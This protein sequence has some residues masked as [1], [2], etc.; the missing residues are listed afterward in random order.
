MEKI[1]CECPRCRSRFKVAPEHIG[2]TG[3]CAK[4]QE[5][6]VVQDVRSAGQI[7]QKTQTYSQSDVSKNTAVYSS[8]SSDKTQTYSNAADAQKTQTYSDTPKGAAT[9]T[10]HAAGTHSDS[11]TPYVYDL[12]Q[13]QGAT[14]QQV[15][16]AHQLGI[17]DVVTLNGSA[18][19]ITGIISQ[20]TGEAVIYNIRNTQQQSLALKLYFEFSN[21]KDEP[22]PEALQRIKEIRDPDILRL[23]DFGTGASKYQNRYCFEICDFAMGGTLLTRNDYSLDCVRQTIIPQIIKGIRTLHQHKIFHCDLKP[24]NIFWLDTDRTDAVIGDYGSA[25]TFEESSQKGLTHTSTTKGTNFYLAPEQPRGIVS[26]KN[27]YYSFGMILLH[28]LYPQFVNRDALHKI[29]ER[30]YERRPIIDYDAK[31]GNLNELIAGLTLADVS[32]RWGEKQVEQWLQGQSISVIYNTTTDIHPI[33]LGTITIKTQAEFT[34]YVETNID[35]FDNLIEDS[36]GYSMVLRWIADIQDLG[37][38]KTFDKMVK[39][40]KQDGIDFLKEAI[41][42]YFMPSRPIQ[43]D[44]KVYDICN[45]TDVAETIEQ[46]F[47]QLDDICVITPLK[48]L[49]FYTFELE[50]ALRHLETIAV[51][52]TKMV[53]ERTCHTI[54]SVLNLSSKKSFDDYLCYWY[55]GITNSIVL[56]V[57]L[58]SFDWKKPLLSIFQDFN[59][60]IDSQLKKMGFSTNLSSAYDYLFGLA[61]ICAGKGEASESVPLLRQLIYRK[62]DFFNKIKK[63]TIL[64]E[65]R[66]IS[67]LLDGIYAQAMSKAKQAI[68][69]AENILNDTREMIS[70][71]QKSAWKV[72]ERSSEMDSINRNYQEIAK[73]F[74]FAQD[75]VASGEYATLLQ[76]PHISLDVGNRGR[77]LTKSA[78]RSYRGWE[79]WDARVEA[80]RKAAYEEQVRRERRKQIGA[81]IGLFIGGVVGCVGGFIVGYVLGIAAGFI[82]FDYGPFWEHVGEVAIGW[83]WAI[84]AFGGMLGGL[85]G[86]SIGGQD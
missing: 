69:E 79:Q 48:T 40:Y 49:K 73:Q 42:R 26:E 53:V 58:Y 10:Y 21:P 83:A 7:S 65:N 13:A 45:S 9:Q 46:F 34:S 25:K 47:Q 39:Y 20:E 5:R 19:T 66:E 6:F 44:M 8:Q 14:G 62:A 72:A 52:E 63:E 29:I 84:S 60:D 77:E 1:A 43:V 54:S 74:Q 61:K 51:N 16:R 24:E 33:K 28:L 22:N 35:W 2:K 57:L 76:V 11:D 67:A 17:G 50:F 59:Q 56:P 78:E 3:K 15:S 82:S 41:L 55:H 64:A 18:Y 32:S 68:S 75:N 27:D 36:E 86:G 4:C 71:A 70:N 37:R 85:I 12:T 23:H 38:K 80:E 81:I 30:Q 31:Y